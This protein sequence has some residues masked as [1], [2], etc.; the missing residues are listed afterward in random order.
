V[1]REHERPAD[2]PVAFVSA[3]TMARVTPRSDLLSRVFRAN[4]A[5][6]F[7]PFS[8]FVGDEREMIKDLSRQGDVTGMLRPHV[9][10]TLGSKAATRS[11]ASLHRARR[12]PGLLPE[13]LRR[14]ESEAAMAGEVARLVLDG[15]LE[16]ERD[17]QFVSGIGAADLVGLEPPDDESDALASLSSAAV[18]YGEA[19]AIDSPLLLSARIYFYNRIPVTPRWAHRLPHRNAVLEFLG[20]AEGGDLRRELDR[21]WDLTPPEDTHDWLMWTPKSS[22]LTRGNDEGMFKIYVSPM[23]GHLRDAVHVLVRE[24][25]EC[26][27]TTFKVGGD[28]NGLLRPDKLVVYFT[29]RAHFEEAAAKLARS[30]AGMSPQGVPFTAPVV[31][32]GLI[33]RGMDPPRSTTL[34]RT[35][36]GESWRQWVT[37]RLAVYL[38][39]ARATRTDATAMT[40]AQFAVARLRLDGVDVRQW[41][42]DSIG[43]AEPSLRGG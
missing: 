26:G 20:L 40:D 4:P 35:R 16:L 31:A 36:G 25:A 18:R 22:T 2:K 7:V 12:S 27:R 39:T 23:P 32:N 21:A 29:D 41:A 10:T 15:I 5:Y 33:S 38:L 34:L 42:P 8:R 19:L 13:R 17:G 43:W 24:L 11:L 28:V 9:R 1:S 30:F 3:A 6:E 37:N 14:A